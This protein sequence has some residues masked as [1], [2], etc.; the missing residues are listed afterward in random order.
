MAGP[1]R[2]KIRERQKFHIDGGRELF[3][4]SSTFDLPGRCISDEV[5]IEAETTG[6]AENAEIL[7]V[8]SGVDLL[9]TIEGDHTI[10]S[11]CVVVRADDAF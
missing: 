1:G 2:S 7:D 9:L 4:A 10:V 11:P 6:S 8:D 5:C 3:A